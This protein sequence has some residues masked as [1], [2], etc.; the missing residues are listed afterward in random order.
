[1]KK[2]KAVKIA[3]TGLALAILFATPAFAGEWKQYSDKWKYQN[4]DGTFSTGWQWINGKSY[5]FDQNGVMYSNT[6][7]PDGYTVNSDG[8]WIV[9][10]KV[11]TQTKEN[12]D[13]NEQYPLAHLQKYFEVSAFTHEI[14]FKWNE[15]N[16][17]FKYKIE[18]PYDYVLENS[19][20]D[21]NVFY[22]ISDTQGVCLLA[23]AKLAG[24]PLTGYEEWAN[25]SKVLAIE[26]ELRNFLN[27]FDWKNASD[28]EKAVAIAKKV[29][30][31]DYSNV[32]EYVHLPY[33]CL[34]EKKAACDGYTNTTEILGMC[35]ELPVSSVVLG[36]STHAFP[37]YCINGVWF[38]H[39]P[40]SHDTYFE[41][42]DYHDALQAAGDYIIEIP[43]VKYCK[44]TGYE[45]PSTD[46]AKAIFNGL[47]QVID[48]RGKFNL[49]FE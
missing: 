24:V 33:G 32:G 4:E 38:R 35:V 7:T 36:F 3:S 25:D 28:Y 37:V 26:N 1:M 11:Q 15:M 43:F 23:M 45:M 8:A 22:F 16:I 40:T 49:Y 44:G 20:K 12:T 17:F 29:N 47:P 19:I 34:V 42:Y 21:K 46:S 31:A 27:S 6:T 10:G 9:D 13:I 14:G 39:E 41:I 18:R 2:N 30:E 48:S 5:C